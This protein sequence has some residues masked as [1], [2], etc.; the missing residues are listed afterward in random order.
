MT[1][2]SDHQSPATQ[3]QRASQERPLVVAIAGA[4]AAAAAQLVRELPFGRG[5]AFILVPSSAA[6]QQPLGTD[7]VQRLTTL[8]VEAVNGELPLASDHVYLVQPEQRVTCGHDSLV[9]SA[10]EAGAPTLDHLFRSLAE[11][12]AE[13]SAAILLSGLR[14]DGSIGAAEMRAAGAL[15]ILEAPATFN[16]AVLPEQQL[17]AKAADM[18]LPLPSMVSALS[19]YFRAGREL[20]ESGSFTAFDG[21]TL[22]PILSVLGEHTGH[23]FARYKRSTVSRRIQRR[24]RVHGMQDPASYAELLEA[25]PAEA[26]LLFN[27]MLI[28]VTRRP[29]RRCRGCSTS[30]CSACPPSTTFASGCRPARP[31]RRLTPSRSCCTSACSG[32]T[33]ATA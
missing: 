1:D 31:A 29:T 19:D 4:D 13:R 8:T 12:H 20:P 2:V 23:D 5:M 30:T 9:G 27:E 14:S 26:E 6:S 18:V 25:R 22:A 33:R 21:R 28:G 11:H 32:P 10:A 16:E 24:M 7:E 15:I 3:P 17:L